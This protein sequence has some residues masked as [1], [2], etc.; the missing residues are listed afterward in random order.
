MHSP[1]ERRLGDECLR[2]SGTRMIRPI[3]PQSRQDIV[4]MDCMYQRIVLL[5]SR[6]S[7]PSRPDLP[8][9]CDLPGYSKVLHS[10]HPGYSKMFRSPVYPAADEKFTNGVCEV[11]QKKSRSC[12]PAFS[13][14]ISPGC[15]RTSSA[16]PSPSPVRWDDRHCWSATPRRRKRSCGSCASPPRCSHGGP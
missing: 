1:Y 9:L 14:R 2:K 7:R 13:G 10:D 15:C 5:V 8:D 11:K 4:H 12:L 3:F 6:P 16:H